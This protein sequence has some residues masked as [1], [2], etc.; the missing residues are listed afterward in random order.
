MGDFWQMVYKQRCAVIIMLT[1]CVES[2]NV[3][4]VLSPGSH[5]LNQT[6]SDSTQKLDEP[7]TVS[8]GDLSHGSRSLP[9][10]LFPRTHISPWSDLLHPM[11][12]EMAA[13]SPDFSET[14]MV[15]V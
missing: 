2:E 6:H 4:K 1:R 5:C 8:G 11:D 12:T 15:I 13:N 3:K 7:Y 14:T 10:C 9:V